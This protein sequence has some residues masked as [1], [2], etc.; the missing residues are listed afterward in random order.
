MPPKKR[1][2]KPKSKSSVCVTC[3]GPWKS[4]AYTLAAVLVVYL[5][6]L[7]GMLIRN[8]IKQYDSIGRTESPAYTITVTGEGEA[9]ATPDVT[10]TTIGIM[11]E[12]ETVAEGQDENAKKINSLLKKLDELGIAKKDIQTQNY[13]VYPRYDYTEDE[14]SVLRGYEVSE[15][16]TIK[17][18]DSALSSKVLALAGEVEATNVSGLQFTFDDTNVYEKQAREAAIVDAKQKARELAKSLGAELGGVVS[19]QEFASGIGVEPFIRSYAE[20]AYGG[21]L[22]PVEPGTKDIRVDVEIIFELK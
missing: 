11:T 17:I 10:V 14:G 18:R 16:V 22:P 8:E 13:N 7:V 2:T 5:I 21:A 15:N 3:I 20:D 19:F 6:V 12:S 1:T 4:L 9:T